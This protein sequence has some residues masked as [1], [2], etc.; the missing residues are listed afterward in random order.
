V[1]RPF[2]LATGCVL[3]W[4]AFGGTAAGQTTVEYGAAA[5]AAAAGASKGAG[6]MLNGLDKALKSRTN[7]AAPRNGATTP[8]KPPTAAPK[9][10]AQ[11]STATPPAK[12]APPPPA[13]TYE[14]PTGIQVGMGYDELLRRF[15][16]PTLEILTGPGTRSLDYDTKDGGVR[17]ECQDGKVIAAGK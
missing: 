2:A 7:P 4:V 9:A 3:G 17:V 10:P 6:G 8:A 13:P 12:V 11:T 16:P 15:G 14:D 5:A 1:I